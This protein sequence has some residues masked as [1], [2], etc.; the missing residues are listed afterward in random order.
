[1]LDQHSNQPCLPASRGDLLAEARTLRSKAAGTRRT[2]DRFSVADKVDLSAALSQIDAQQITPEWLATKA[3][4]TSYHAA[5]KLLIR[6]AFEALICLRGDHA[7]ARAVLDR[8]NV[9]CIGQWVE[10][11]LNAAMKVAN[12]QYQLYRRSTAWRIRKAKQDARFERA[13][14]LR[15]VSERLDVSVRRVRVL[16]TEKTTDPNVA[17][18]LAELLGGNPSYYLRRAKKRGPHADLTK[19]VLALPLGDAAFSDFQLHYAMARVFGSVAPR[20]VT[21]LIHWGS[22][23]SREV[24]E[25]TWRNFLLWRIDR[26]RQHVVESRHV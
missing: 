26:L 22:G 23:V 6:I 24:I 11:D 20:S 12:K 9:D 19:H 21:D 16:A 3:P 18:I 25:S 4:V 1:M 15:R 2:D 5:P 10:S 13:E 17:S 14:K 8:W 7:K